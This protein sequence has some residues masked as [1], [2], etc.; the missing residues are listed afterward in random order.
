RAGRATPAPPAT[1][2]RYARPRFLPP[3]QLFS[4]PGCVLYGSLTDFLGRLVRM[5][6][7]SNNRDDRLYVHVRRR[8]C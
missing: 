8:Y 5:L 1:S 7:D 3:L 6:A 2:A 4:V